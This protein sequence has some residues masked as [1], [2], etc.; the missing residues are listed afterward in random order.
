MAP[1][2]NSSSVRSAHMAGH[3]HAQ[4][5]REQA[6]QGEGVLHDG[7]NG[8]LGTKKKIKIKKKEC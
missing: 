4:M 3:E 2:R 6:K 7:G 1:I 8:T 5:T